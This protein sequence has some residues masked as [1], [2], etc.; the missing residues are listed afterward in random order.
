MYIIIYTELHLYSRSPRNYIHVHVHCM[1]AYS[2]TDRH[3][4]L[5]VGWAESKGSL[6]RSWAWRVLTC[7]RVESTSPPGGRGPQKI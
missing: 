6:P 2:H 3:T 5:L 4:F 1:Y 7:S